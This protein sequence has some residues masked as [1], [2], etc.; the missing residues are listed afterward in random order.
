MNR[1][2]NNTAIY[3]AYFKT[4]TAYNFKTW[5]HTKRNRSKIKDINTTFFFWKHSGEHVGLEMK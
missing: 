3:K 4:I 1:F 2:Q 5:K